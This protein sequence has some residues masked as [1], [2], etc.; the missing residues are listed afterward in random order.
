MTWPR[1]LVFEARLASLLFVIV[2]AV[3]RHP[4]LS[5][6]LFICLVRCSLSQHLLALALFAG[7]GIHWH[8]C[9]CSLALVLAFAGVGIGVCWCCLLSWLPSLA[10]SPYEQW[11]AGGVLVPCD[12]ASTSSLSRNGACY[13][14]VSLCSQQR[15]RAQ[16]GVMI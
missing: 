14:P 4:V 12:V 9:W 13:D 10:I 1:H 11:L 2:P 3:C 8:W 6:L 5:S 7:I 16:V 15:H